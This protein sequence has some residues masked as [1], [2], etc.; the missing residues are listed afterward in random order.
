MPAHAPGWA[1]PSAEERPHEQL[2]ALCGSTQ[3][4][5]LCLFAEGVRNY[6]EMCSYNQ[7]SRAGHSC[8]PCP[9]G[10]PPLLQ[11]LQASL[12]CAVTLARCTPP[13]LH[14]VLANVG[15]NASVWLRMTTLPKCN[16]SLPHEPYR[17]ISSSMIHHPLQIYLFCY[18]TAGAFLLCICYIFRCDALR[19]LRLMVLLHSAAILTADCYSTTYLPGYNIY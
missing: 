13:G 5:R 8:K 3:R 1:H 10:T 19:Y 16:I 11:H 4:F 15:S 2:A 9:K 12:A 7:Y 18:C 17:V 14:L 6:C